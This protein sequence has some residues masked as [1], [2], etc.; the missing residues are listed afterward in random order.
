MV[1]LV[2]PSSSMVVPK[3]SDRYPTVPAGPLVTQ[4]NVPDR[5]EQCECP[6]TASVK[7]WLLQETHWA[8]FQQHDI[9]NICAKIKLF[10]ITKKLL[11]IVQWTQFK[12]SSAVTF[13]GAK[14][15]SEIFCK[16]AK[17]SHPLEYI[18]L[19]SALEVTTGTKCLQ[20]IFA[21]FAFSSQHSEV[22]SFLA[23]L[24][25]TFWL[26]G[27]F[28]LLK[29]MQ[30]SESFYENEWRL[31]FVKGRNINSDVWSS[32]SFSIV[33]ENGYHVDVHNWNLI[34]YSANSWSAVQSAK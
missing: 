30:F 7:R 26:N 33:N 3:R 24:R 11:W 32:T 16:I 23:S 1:D 27:I 21:S 12:L 25:V 6:F 9:V 29:A 4:P 10:V 28:L 17:P 15:P 14:Y 22:F 20:N 34:V 19:N 2:G 18:W 5:L 31:L 8:G 13:Y